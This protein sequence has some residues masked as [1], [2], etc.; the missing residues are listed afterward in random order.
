MPL[1]FPWTRHRKAGRALG[2]RDAG[3]ELATGNVLPGQWFPLERYSPKE[4]S[5]GPQTMSYFSGSVLMA[6]YGSR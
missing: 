3:Q 2:Y 5:A 1:G 6:C 4:L